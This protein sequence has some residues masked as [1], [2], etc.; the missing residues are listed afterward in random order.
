MGQVYLVM[1]DFFESVNLTPFVL[2]NP[3]QPLGI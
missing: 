1:Y 3:G 2:T